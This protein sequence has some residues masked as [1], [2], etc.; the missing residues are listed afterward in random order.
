MRA[1]RFGRAARWL[2]AACLGRAAAWGRGTG[3]EGRG[4]TF[5]SPLVLCPSSCSLEWALAV[6]VAA[7]L[8]TVAH[9]QPRQVELLNADAVEV[10]TSEL[11]GT[12]RRLTGDVRMRQDTTA[13]RADRA[14]QFVDRG[15]IELT[16]AVRIISGTDTLTAAR[17]VYDSIG[18]VARATGDVRVG[19]GASTLFAPAV[20]YRSREETSAF[21]GGGRILHEGAEIVAPEGTYSS[22]SRIARLRGPLTIT[23]SAGV[24]TADRGV[25]DARLQRADLAGAVHLERERE[26]LDADSLVYFRRTERARAFGQVVLERRELP[27][28]TA[29]GDVRRRAFL[30]GERLLFDGQAETAAMRSD[31]GRGDGAGSPPAVRDPLLVVLD[32]DSLG[33][34]DTTYARA[35]RL[36]ASRE[37]VA[38]PGAPA[39]TVQVLTAA[40]GARLVRSD[41][42]ALADSARFVRLAP[43]DGG[44]ALDRL[45]LFD[46]QRP[47]VWADGAQITGD[48]LFATAR[49]DGREGG[50]LD[51]LR[52]IGDAFLARPDS[53]TGRLAQ[54]RG[55]RMLARLVEG[56]V[57]RLSVWPNAEAL[58]FRADADGALAGADRVSADSLA[59][60]F[61]SGELR[62]VV[63]VRGI[64]G[65]AYPASAVP[66]DLAL[67]GLAYAPDDRPTAA[68]LLR[69]DDWER[70]W[71][72]AFA[73]EPPAPDPSAL[74]P[75]EL[76]GADPEVPELGDAGAPTPGAEP[77]AGPDAEPAPA[78]P[79]RDGR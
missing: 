37:L 28:S 61:A 57:H 39:D 76:D 11:D 74:D 18:K 3:D 59:F 75:P 20:S 66:S 32:R 4:A 64:E 45:A 26:A 56:Q 38:R 19:D 35:P 9:A 5:P 50:G 10:T 63:G 49:G 30:F 14:V 22:A 47:R 43:G 60:R 79:P 25:Y 15:E 69:P 70:R 1:R 7:I 12:I 52:V 51:T 48:T 58:Y 41:L 2:G 55:G 8:P 36:D 44:T 40:G 78:D 24:A 31:L 33:T 34:V 68:A 42:Q 72:D 62:E 46:P 77:E 6:L 67:P 29:G 54:I 16:G 71:L 21:T 53:A 17:V 73:A 65:T 27:D 23:D 13:L